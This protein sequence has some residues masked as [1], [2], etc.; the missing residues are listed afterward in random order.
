KEEAAKLVKSGKAGDVQEHQTDRMQSPDRKKAEFQQSRTQAMP[1]LSKEEAEREA[2]TGPNRAAASAEGASGGAETETKKSPVALIAGV[3]IVL[4]LVAGWFMFGGGG[5]PES[6]VVDQKKL[7][8]ADEK[9]E[10]A[11]LDSLDLEGN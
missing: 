10:K 2:K 5:K 7:E 3:L 11:L 9:I 8:A 4:A 6:N 1:G